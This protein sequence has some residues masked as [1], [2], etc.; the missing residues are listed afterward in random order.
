M[1]G[2]QNKT[3]CQVRFFEL[4]TNFQVQ[5]L[6]LIAKLFLVLVYSVAS[7]SDIQL[8]YTICV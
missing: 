5:I 1:G 2:L 8:V 7:C 6:K 3:N 4:I